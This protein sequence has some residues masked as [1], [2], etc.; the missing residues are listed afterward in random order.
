VGRYCHW[1][2]YPSAMLPTLRELILRDGLEGALH[3]LTIANAGWS[4]IRSDMPATFD[5]AEPTTNEP[6]AYL[7]AI[8]AFITEHGRHPIMD[9]GR[10]DGRFRAVAGYGVAYTVESGQVDADEWRTTADPDEWE[11]EYAYALTPDGVDVWVNGSNGWR[12]M[13]PAELEAELHPSNA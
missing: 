1:D 7:A 10:G 4:S 3:T 12:R 13:T 11:C 5:E 2:G 6:G 8:N 9:P